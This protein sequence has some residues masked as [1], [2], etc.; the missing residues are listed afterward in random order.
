M[1]IRDLRH[2]RTYGRKYGRKGAFTG[3]KAIALVL[4]AAGIMLMAFIVVHSTGIYK[5]GRAAEERQGLASVRCVGFLYTVK[6]MHA[7]AAALEFELKNEI[8]STEDVHNLTV[9]SESQS[10]H[11]A[12]FIP[13]GSS[14]AVRVPLAVRTNFTLYPDNCQIYPARCKISGEC[15]YR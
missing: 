10:R 7:T 4:L 3:A 13:I 5:R 1:F 2:G 12:V 11:V 8:S 15:A 14:A 6:N 9:T